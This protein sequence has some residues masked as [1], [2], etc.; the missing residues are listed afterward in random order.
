[1]AHSLPIGRHLECAVQTE[2]VVEI[3]LKGSNLVDFGTILSYARKIRKGSPRLALCQGQRSCRAKNKG[4]SS[5][6]TLSYDF[7][8]LHHSNICA[9]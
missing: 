3:E 5:V 1:M 2:L 8:K 6:K 7:P 4:K 9:T